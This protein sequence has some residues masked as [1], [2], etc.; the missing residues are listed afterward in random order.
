M[1]TIVIIHLTLFM[2]DS[3]MSIIKT[4]FWIACFLYIAV[5]META[6]ILGIIPSPFYSHQIPFRAIWTALSRKGH[7]VV[8]VTTDPIN[9]PSLTNLTEI[10]FHFMN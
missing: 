6:R 7:E 3:E 5:P 2:I 10:T 9:N 4:I 8:L 1:S